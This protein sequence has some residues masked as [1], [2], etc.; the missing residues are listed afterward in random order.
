M[1]II[2][3]IRRDDMFVAKKYA[4]TGGH[5][6]W[7]IDEVI[8]DEIVIRATRAQGDFEEEE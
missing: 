4:S 8:G 1:V 7:H 5:H 6:L 3:G 2:Q